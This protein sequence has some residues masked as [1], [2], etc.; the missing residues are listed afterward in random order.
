MKRRI[1]KE[2]CC[3]PVLPMVSVPRGSNMSFLIHV[4]TVLQVKR[5]KAW[6]TSKQKVDRVLFLAQ[7]KHYTIVC[8]NFSCINTGVLCPQWE[9]VY[10]ADTISPASLQAVQKSSTDIIWGKVTLMKGLPSQENE[11]L[12]K[13]SIVKT[14]KRVL[15]IPEGCATRNIFTEMQLLSGTGSN[16]QL[17]EVSSFLCATVSFLKLP[18]GL[19]KVNYHKRSI[20]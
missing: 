14:E 18:L 10:K 3:P 16:S 8:Q 11:A 19:T 17:T 15:E 20:V 13:A 7:P 5:G 9:Q 4:I 6:Y 12:A 2:K 1:K